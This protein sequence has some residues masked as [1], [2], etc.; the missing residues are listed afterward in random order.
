M[1]YEVLKTEHSGSKKGCGAYW[2]R[3]AD[4]KKQSNRRRREQG[5][6]IIDKRII[7]YGG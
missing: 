5:K 7:H 3:K 2:G 4:A 6:T 1:G